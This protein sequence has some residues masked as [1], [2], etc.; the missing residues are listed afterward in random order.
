MTRPYRYAVALVDTR[1]HRADVCEAELFVSSHIVKNLEALD[2]ETA[3]RE[4]E[5]DD[6][7]KVVLSAKEAAK[8]ATS[9]YYK[10]RLLLGESFGT[11]KTKQILNSLDK[12]RID[13]GQL[14]SQSAFIGKSLDTSIHKISEALERE[15]DLDKDTASGPAATSDSLLPPHN[16]QTKRVE[17]IYKMQD[18]IPGEVYYSLQV[19]PIVASLQKKDAD[20]L[21]EA[22]APYSLQDSILGRIKSLAAIVTTPSEKALTHTVR[23]LIYLNHLLSFRELNETKVNGDLSA[24][25]PMATSDLVASL[26]SRFTETVTVST[27]LQRYKLSSACRDRL[28]IHICILLL[29]LDGFRTNTARLSVALK[30]SSLKAVDYLKAVGCTIEKPLGEEPA[31][32]IVPGTGRELPVKIGVLKAP[33]TII[34]KKALG[35]AARRK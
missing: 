8:D 12:N 33:L 16:A 19:K 34:S 21:E 26:L 9:A 35:P 13:M 30:V 14:E 24:S 3:Q 10:S 31:K 20:L 22:I 17:E 4:E 5:D 1:T 32:Y 11:R 23:C 6:S 2:A 29:I 7:D 28:V 25:M 18:L 15:K 27:G